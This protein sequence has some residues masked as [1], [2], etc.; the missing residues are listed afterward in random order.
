MTLVRASEGFYKHVSHDGARG[1]RRSNRD[2]LF[3]RL[4]QLMADGKIS[5][6]QATRAYAALNKRADEWDQES[7]DRLISDLRSGVVLSGDLKVRSSR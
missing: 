6:S 2:R 3:E 5:A 1:S 4:A 7:L